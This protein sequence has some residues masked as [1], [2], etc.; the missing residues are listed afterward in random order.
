M[1]FDK[2]KNW[3]KTVAGPT[4]ECPLCHTQNPEDA[5]ECSQCMY[6]LGK[7]AFEQVAAVDD[8]EAGTLFDELLAEIDEDDDE[9]VIDWSHKLLSGPRY[10]TF[11][12]CIVFIVS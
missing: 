2:F 12:P 9:E 8:E 3:R 5:S 7:A 10:F 6:Q 11:G 4:V 1:V